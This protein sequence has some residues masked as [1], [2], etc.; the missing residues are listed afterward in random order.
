MSVGEVR[1]REAEEI[2]WAYRGRLE[3]VREVHGDGSPAV[4]AALIE[5]DDAETHLQR[6]REALEGG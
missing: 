4:R 6:S 3:R 2:V 5:L 1:V